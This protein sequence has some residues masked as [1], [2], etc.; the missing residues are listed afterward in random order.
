MLILGVCAIAARGAGAQASA[1]IRGVVRDSAAVVLPNADV[2]V[3]PGARRVRTDS[4]GRFR[5]DSLEAGKYTVK[6]RRVGYL[7]VEWTVDLSRSGR[8]DMQLVLGGRLPML[9]TVVVSAGRT[10]NTGSI[11]G[12]LCRRASAKGTFFDYTDIDDLDL[13]D[14]ADL[15]QTVPGFAVDVRPTR[16]GPRRMPIGRRCINT[17]LD[18]VPARWNDVPS[19]PADIMAVEIYEHPNDI[20]REYN[21]YTWGKEQ[22]SLIV[23][24]T[25]NFSR[26][27]RSVKLP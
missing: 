15:F 2:T 11:E 1:S 17:L 4:A 13:Y 18:G 25:V 26:P 16:A 10:C 23:Y 3:T 24:W 14:T 6:A 19:E 21:K 22:C 9:D 8:A 20:P 12:F 7:P 27:L 5:I